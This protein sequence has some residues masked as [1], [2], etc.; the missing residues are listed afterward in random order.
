L[1]IG[2]LAV[3]AAGCCLHHSVAENDLHDRPSSE[4]EKSYQKEAAA[5]VNYEW[6]EPVT[7]CAD[8]YA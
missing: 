1:E 4:A 2:T 5:A 6:K 3:V 7:L 8:A